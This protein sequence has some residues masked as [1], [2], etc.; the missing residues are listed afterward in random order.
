MSYKTHN[1]IKFIG[2]LFVFFTAFMS[3][4]LGITLHNQF[5]IYN[6]ESAISD[7][8]EQVIQPNYDT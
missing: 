8:N 5:C 3:W 2:M 4:K 1:F 6:D 7:L